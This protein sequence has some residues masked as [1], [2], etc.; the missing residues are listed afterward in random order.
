MA[1][2]GK[3]PAREGAP[4]APAGG[5]VVLE[6]RG[7]SCGYGARA[8][9]EDV[10]FSVRAGEVLCLLGPNGVGKTTLFRTVLGLLEPVAGSTLVLGRDLREWTERQLARRV[11]YIAQSHTPAF[12]YTVEQVVL[13]GRTPYVSGLGGPGGEDEAI[14]HDAME[15]LGIE[16]LAQRDYTQLSGGEQQLVMIARALAQRPR[17]LVMDEPCASLDLGNQALLL[18]QTARLAEEGMAVVMTTHDPNHAFALDGEVLCLG[19][20]GL[21]ASGRAGEVLNGEVMER[22]YGVPVAVGRVGGEGAAGAVACVPLVRAM[23]EGGAS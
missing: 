8:V 12:S 21:A 10:S 16:G 2:K 20:E 7:L 23:R 6:A 15:R 13:M 9:V 22:L 19:Q 17:L 1:A 4:A 14:A 11:A 5:E 3:T 18:R